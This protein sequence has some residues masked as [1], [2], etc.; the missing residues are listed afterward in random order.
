[1]SLAEFSLFLPGSTN[2]NYLSSLKK[3]KNSKNNKSSLISMGSNSNDIKINL[4]KI[5]FNFKQLIDTIISLIN[6][7]KKLEDEILELKTKSQKQKNMLSVKKNS[8]ELLKYIG[9]L[10]DYLIN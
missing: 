2:T 5:Q 6:D 3:S 9:V 1:M 7:K 10:D 4:K 8:S